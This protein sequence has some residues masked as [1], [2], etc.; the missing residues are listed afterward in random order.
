VWIACARLQ[1][2]DSDIDEHSCNSEQARL[3]VADFA[4]RII[5][6]KYLRPLQSELAAGTAFSELSELNSNVIDLLAQRPT[7][8]AA[9]QAAAEQGKDGDFARYIAWQMT[10]D[11]RHLEKIYGDEIITANNRM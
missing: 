2:V 7:W 3:E 6:E 5:D 1:H 10:G 8:G 4:Q 9:L 11:T